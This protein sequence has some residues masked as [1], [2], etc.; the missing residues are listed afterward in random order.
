MKVA[1]DLLAL[2]QDKARDRLQRANASAR[3]ANPIHTRAAQTGT[4][5]LVTGSL[6]VAVVQ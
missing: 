6:V 2:L 1:R 5:R 4:G 3:A